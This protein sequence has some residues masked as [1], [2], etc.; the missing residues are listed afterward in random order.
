MK[1]WNGSTKGIFAFCID[2]ALCILR[3]LRSLLSFRQ[4]YAQM[5]CIALPAIFR[6]PV[7]V[8]K[9]FSLFKPTKAYL[10]IIISLVTAKA[11]R[12]IACADTAEIGV[13]DAAYSR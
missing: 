1:M 6:F 3:C 11:K 4:I 2:A 12:C 10:G 9:V 5:D 8:K 7:K 13:A